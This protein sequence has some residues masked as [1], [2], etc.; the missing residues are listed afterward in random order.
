[1]KIAQ[2]NSVYISVPPKTHG[3]T[4]RIVYYLCREL[5]LRGHH[6]ELFA[7]GDSK[8]ECEL[9]AVLPIA[10]QDDPKSTFYLEKEFEARNTYNLYRQAERFDVIHAHW[11]TLAPYFSAFVKTPTLV[12]YAYI[13]K[14]LHEYYR[15]HFPHCL[16]VCVSQ[17][18]RKMLGDESIPVVYNAVDLDEISFNDQPED[19][20]IIVGRMTPGKGIA[21]AI[22]IAKKARA[23]LRHCRPRH[24]SPAL[25]RGVL[26]QRRSS[27]TSTEIASVISSGWPI[28]TRANDGQGQRLPLSPAVG[29][30]VRYGRDRSHGCGNSGASLPPR[31]R[32]RS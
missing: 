32:C 14:E 12:T 13:E 3:G 28:T 17:A 8:V 6:V 25:E 27:R 20:F 15:K 23:R 24:H 26:S 31:A 21:E 7:S 19:F 29:R 1:M 10:S 30:A 11:T 22:R 9:Q 5:T 18:Q 4:E 2:I 16:P